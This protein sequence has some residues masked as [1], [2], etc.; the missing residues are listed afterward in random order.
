MIGVSRRHQQCQAALTCVLLCPPR[1]LEPTLRVPQATGVRAEKALDAIIT[2]VLIVDYWGI[3]KADVGLTGNKIVGI[4]K[5]GN[6][7][8]M[9]GVAE[10]MV[11]GVSA[12]CQCCCCTLCSA[13]CYLVNHPLLTITLGREEGGCCCCL[14]RSLDHLVRF[15]E[16]VWWGEGEGRV[17]QGGE[18]KVAKMKSRG[19][20]PQK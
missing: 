13:S 7:D 12:L 15:K 8:V 6:P 14:L 2:N 11:V 3:V 18:S 9:D 5:G 4:G 10:N 19:L 20:V 17:Q 16:K 1:P